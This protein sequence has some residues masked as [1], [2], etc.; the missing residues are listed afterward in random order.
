MSTLVQAGAKGGRIPSMRET[1]QRG[2]LLVRA[3]RRMNVDSL[4]HGP[5]SDPARAASAMASFGAHCL[6]GIPTQLFAVAHRVQG[7]R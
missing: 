1:G 5:V 3:L 4:A 2:G 6:V 7:P